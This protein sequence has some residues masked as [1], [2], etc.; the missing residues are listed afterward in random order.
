MICKLQGTI[1]NVY[2]ILKKKVDFVLM[3]GITAYWLQSLSVYCIWAS[4]FSDLL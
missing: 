1:G 2:L 3:A 4:W